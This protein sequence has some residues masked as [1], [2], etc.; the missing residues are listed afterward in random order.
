MSKAICVSETYQVS[1]RITHIDSLNTANIQGLIGFFPCSAE[2]K[3]HA[4]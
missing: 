1:L 2:I 4:A 3:Q